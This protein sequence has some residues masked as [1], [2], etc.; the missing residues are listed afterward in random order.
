M[1]LPTPEKIS[2]KDW[3]RHYKIDTP[4]FQLTPV[5]KPDMSPFLIHMTG[6]GA[7]LSILKGEN[8]PTPVAPGQGYLKASV[9]EY[10]SG[11]FDAKV[12]CFSESPTFAVDF[13]RY[14][15]FDRW[16]ANQSY[17]IGFDKAALA[18]AGARP[19][20]YVDEKIR[21]HVIYLYHRIQKHKLV[22]SDDPEVHERL[23]E[24][25]TTIY[26]LLYPLLEDHQSQGFMW[27]REWRYTD[28]AGFVFGHSDIKIICCPDNEVDGIKQILGNAASQIQ[29]VGTWQEYDDVT[30]YLR[31]QQATW[32][33]R[34]QRIEKLKS[35][36][37][38]ALRLENLLHQYTQALNS[39]D[40]YLGFL[41]RFQS[42]MDRVTNERAELA[43][44][45]S[46]LNQQLKNLSAKKPVAQI[47]SPKTVIQPPVK[48]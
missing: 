42:E 13:F 46:E 33:V 27:E 23:V 45:V 4:A 5:E 30:D 19:V 15:K 17:G 37:K 8:A 16:L 32:H 10:N 39:L 25:I 2:W 7:I 11:A 35:S 28:P 36:N 38:E 29:F 1:A 48:K 47:T 41:S 18:R 26:P 6:K 20:I 43:Q 24:A 34:E 21:K 40:A 22:L 12:V 44:K 3:S 9:P 31:R 14:R